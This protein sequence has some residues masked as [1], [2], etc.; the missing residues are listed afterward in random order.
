LLLNLSG[1]DI[2]R[3]FAGDCRVLFDTVGRPKAVEP[4]KLL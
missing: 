4:V 2:Q 3:R 1:N